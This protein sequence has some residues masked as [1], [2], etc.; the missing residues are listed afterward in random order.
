MPTASKLVAG[1][2]FALVA[3][4][5]SEV[6]KPLLPEG[7]QVGLLTPLNS[8]IGFLCGW[9]V[10][11]KLVGR[12]YYSAAG[13]GVR[14]SCTVLFFALVLWS[15]Y[16]MILLSTRLRYDGPMDALTGMMGMIVEYFLLMG[17]D[18]QGPIILIVGGILGGFLAEWI[19]ERF[20]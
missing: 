3:M 17:T 14:T 12:G 18:P 15:C 13:A 6:F 5:A 16:Q 1:L 4:F 10:M 2:T 9:I 20:A 7:T 19:S 8:F 11:G